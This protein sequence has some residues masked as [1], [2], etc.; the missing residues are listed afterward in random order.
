MTD[1]QRIPAYK[2][3]REGEGIRYKF[4][5]ELSEAAVCTTEVYDAPSIE[6]G[7]ALAWVKEGRSFFNH[8]KKCSRYV[9]DAMF[10][11]EVLECV[12]CAPYEAE[13]KYCKSCGARVSDSRNPCP[14]CSKPLVY[15]GKELKYEPIG[16][17]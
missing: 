16:Q 3:V 8:C 14:E 10:N 11:V 5:C 2:T 9:S 7:A 17:S 4:L 6:E 13:A 1:N 12:A 15:L